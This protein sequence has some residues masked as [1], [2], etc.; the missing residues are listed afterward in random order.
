MGDDKPV[1]EATA[2]SPDEEIVE[3]EV[4]SDGDVAEGLDGPGEDAIQAEL[5]RLQQEAGQL[6]ELYLRKLADFDNFRKRKDKEMAEYRR[7]SNS[8]LLRDLLPVVDNL[9]RALAVG[10]EDVGGVRTGVELTLRQF[11]DVL[12]R[13]GVAEV[14]PVGQQ[15]D[16]SQHEAVSRLH[17][18]E[19]EPNTVLQVLQKGYCLGD[20]LLRAA[21]VVVAAPA[22]P[23]VAAGSEAGEGE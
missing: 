1:G 4:P 3:L 18:S 11:K 20:R 6:R 13:H 22:A 16:P 15:F 5:A 12:S 8:E 19:A 10:G 7:Q 2:V 21:L 14:N 9:E 17:T 23:G